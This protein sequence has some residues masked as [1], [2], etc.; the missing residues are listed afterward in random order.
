MILAEKHLKIPS[1]EEDVRK[2]TIGDVVYLTGRMHTMRDMGHRRALD[3]LNRGEKLP[4]SI[5]EG[6]IWHCGPIARKENNEWKFLSA[7]PTSSSRFTELGAE[8]I[9]RLKVRFTV[10]KGTMG[11]STVDAMKDVG[12]VYLIATGGCAAVYAKKILNIDTVYW[13]DLGMPEATW[14]VNAK[15]FGPLVVGI[16]SKGNSL[17]NNLIKEIQ[18]NAPKIFDDLGIDYKRRYVWW[19]KKTVG[20]EEVYK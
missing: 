18:K 2:L 1:L 19:P 16:D 17:A 4:F 9:R 3:I 5:N 20:S 14:V 15:E 12:A 7:G 6:C 11:K 10:G 8:L 13:L